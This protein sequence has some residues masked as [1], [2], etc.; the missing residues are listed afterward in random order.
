M[1]KH[2][3]AGR[4]LAAGVAAIALA[5]PA[6]V[7]AATGSPTVQ[8]QPIDD[9]QLQALTETLGGAKPSPTTR[10]IPHWWGST[11]DPD[12]STTYGYNM[13][14]ADPNH[15][16]GSACSVTVQVDIT[17]INLNID[18]MTFRG[19]DVLPPLLASPQFSLNDY[20]STPYATTGGYFTGSR[21]PGGVLSQGDAGIPLQLQDATM[22]A[23]FNQVGN[24]P[25]H[26]KLH[27]NILPALTIDVPAGDAT[28]RK[29][30]RGTIFAAA[31]IYWW[32]A[33]INHLQTT[34][35]PTHLPLYVTDDT[36]LDWNAPGG[37]TVCCVLGFHGATLDGGS[38]GNSPLQ[39]YAWASYL[40]PGIYARPDGA[41]YWGLQDIDAFSHEISEWSD[42]PFVNNA[43]EGWQLPIGCGGILETG[44]PV[45][46]AAFAMGSNTFRQGPNPNG[47][48]TADGYYHPEDEVTLP[49]FMHLAPNLVSEPTQ[50]PSPNVGRY[51]FMGDLNTDGFFNAPP[52]A[53]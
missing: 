3:L 52:P 40:S 42:D 12:N 6:S 22:R 1:F 27:P 26:L 28:L 38:Q 49:W 15:C 37:T 39:T 31:S 45:N 14:G 2:D 29:S 34:A 47:T 11:L 7:S 17:P 32:A 35:D 33:L 24:S 41:K 23:Q 10:T 8:P 25:Y 4:L 21:G 5:A 48:Q 50:S 16:S 46:L 20:G 13:V 53:C 36:L 30:G 18:G 43:T 9:S 51:T 19:T 44:D